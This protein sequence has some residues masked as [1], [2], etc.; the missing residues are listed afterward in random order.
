MSLTIVEHHLMIDYHY[1]GTL[2]TALAAPRWLSR[3][4][5]ECN[6]SRLVRLGTEYKEKVALVSFPLL[7]GNSPQVELTFTQI[8]DLVIHQFIG[9]VTELPSVPL[10]RSAC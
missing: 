2:S 6:C 7:L 5:F 3:H 1:L 8:S 9:C 10:N 4:I